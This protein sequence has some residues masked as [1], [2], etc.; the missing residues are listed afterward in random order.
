M[1]FIQIGENV[2]NSRLLLIIIVA[3]LIPV[4]NS[5]ESLLVSLCIVLRLP[6]KSLFIFSISLQGLLILGLIVLIVAVK[7]KRYQPGILL[8]LQTF[9]FV[10]LAL[11]SIMVV[12]IILNY[13]IKV[14]FPRTLDLDQINTTNIDAFDLGYLY[15]TQSGLVILRN[16]ILFI[17]YFAIVFEK[18][19]R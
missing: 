17:A 13:Y 4:I 16:V 6:L 18:S 15:F 11:L 3:L 14:N 1:E 19:T 2:K 9:R 5:V 8:S 10:G 7:A 12:A